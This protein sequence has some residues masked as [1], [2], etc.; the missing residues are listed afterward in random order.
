M[1][2]RYACWGAVLLAGLVGLWPGVAG[3]PWPHWA[4]DA[5]HTGTARRAPMRLDGAAWSA[6]PRAPSGEREEF[7][8]RSGPVT[9]DGRVFVTSRRYIDD[10]S[11]L[12]THT[13]NTVICYDAHDGTR[14]WD[15]LIDA[16]SYEYD[17]WATPAID[18]TNGTLLVASHF[19]LFALDVDDGAIVWRR[20]LPGVLVNASPTVSAGL[21]NAGVP[22]DRVF[23]TDY[24]GFGPTDG[25]IYAINVSPFDALGNP[26]EPGE[27]VWQDRTLP[28]TSGNTATYVDGYVYVASSLGGVIR[29]YAALDGGAAEGG[30]HPDWETDTGVSQ[31]AQYA[32]FYGGVSVRRGYVYAAAYQFYGTGNSSR[33]YK[34]A[35]ADGA[36]IW[37][38]AC[39]RTD[40]IP[41]VSDE[42]HIYLAGGID[43]FGSAVKIQAFA[44]YGSY[45]ALLWDTYVDTDGALYLGGWTHQPLLADG[46]LYCG[47]PDESQFFGPYT[48]LYVLDVTRVPTDPAFVVDYAAGAGGRPAT[49]GRYLYSL[50]DQGLVAY[51]GCGEGD[52]DADGDVDVS[53][54]AAWAPCLAGPNVLTPPP[55]CG[56]AM[57]RCAALDGDGA[58]DLHDLAVLQRAVSREE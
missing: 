13:A 26:Y 34:L 28:G 27:I 17:S 9:A 6:Q 43:G 40:S 49:T 5:A 42:G 21:R 46:R 53:D 47:R 12:W 1:S 4:G 36:L 11:G 48:G 51:R 14:R 2:T 15:T 39:E 29:R 25:G 7:V 44:D 30:V 31:L 18:L 32:G 24:T 23:I 35:A 45:A 38:Q 54:A 22:A 58:V 3:E 33:L 10:G 8:W 50:G 55:D 37:E 16:D 19:T 57:F 52:M 56:V 20:G 41:V